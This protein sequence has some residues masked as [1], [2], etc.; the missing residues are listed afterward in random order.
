MYDERVEYLIYSSLRIDHSIHKAG[1]FPNHDKTLLILNLRTLKYD[2]F[3][4]FQTH[5][6]LQLRHFI[7]L[8]QG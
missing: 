3:G 7:N 2:S 5:P 8:A 4:A 1:K 6:K